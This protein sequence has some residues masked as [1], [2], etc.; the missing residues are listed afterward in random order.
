MRLISLEISNFR[1]IR[2]VSL[3]FPDKVIGIIGP[4]GAGKSSIIEA[5]AWALYGNQAA[6]T[7]R[8]EIKSVFARPTDNCE[9]SLGFSINEEKYRVVRRLVGKSERAEV[10]LYRG[11]SS[12]SVGVNE[13]KAYVGQLLGLDWRGFLSSFLA[14]QQELN[15]LSDLQ[16]SKRRDHLAGMLG[17]ERLDKAI[18]RV[19]EDTKLSQEKARFIENQLV[20]K[21]Q[22]ESRIAQLNGM[23]SG[24]AEPVGKLQAE[25]RAAEAEFKAVEKEFNEAQLKR[26]R[27]TRLKAQIEANEQTLESLN[28]Q[29]DRYRE[30]IQKLAN[31]Q[32]ELQKLNERLVVF[33]EVKK[34]LESLR[35]IKSRLAVRDDLMSR[36]KDMSDELAQLQEDVKKSEE[37]IGGIRTKLGSFPA[38]FEKI[39][40]EKKENLESAREAYSKIKA[41]AT[42]LQKEADKLKSQLLSIEQLGPDSICD[43]CLRPFGEDYDGI[44]GHLGS[45]LEKLQQEMKRLDGELVVRKKSGEEL[46][47]EVTQLERVQRDIYQLNVDLKAVEK[48]R[49]L[50]AAAYEKTQMKLSEISAELK[51]YEGEVFDRSKFEALTVQAEQLE[52]IKQHSDQLKGGLVRLPVAQKGLEE[53]GKRFAD[54]EAT[55][56][57]GRSELDTLGASEQEFMKVSERFNSVRDRLDKVKTDL[58]SKVKEKELHEKELE[59]R[60]DQLKSYQKAAVELEQSRSAHYYGEKLARLF[61]DFRQNLVAGIRPSLSEI[62]SRLFGDMTDGKYT[63]VDLDEK[64]NLR[65]MDSGAYYGVD[66]FSGGEKD[67]ANLCLRLAIS[68]ALTESAGLQRSFVILDEVFG[69]QDAQRKEL[70]LQAMAKLKS[71]FPQILLITHIEDVKDGVEEIIEVLPTGSGW[72]EVRV[73]GASV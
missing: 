62:S 72:S 71:R 56:S 65:I 68:L 26:E 9:V 64:Y 2:N 61:A 70:I 32:G 23:I 38:D 25:L 48:T 42:S 40:A 22:V 69:S 21:V 55:L 50:A 16:P 73:N 8:D 14:R 13:T 3:T 11:D 59:S 35:E 15:A 41:E 57:Q 63:L 12:E 37:R 5:V 10:E 49:Q 1:V 45:E 39:L 36:K 20:D 60:L 43:R 28:E 46:A 51:K 27:W 24:L 58:M 17:I 54:V 30:E 67:L 52:G 31:D 19:K 66:R 53:T 29:A 18:Q 6:R 47:T 34:Q 7:G 33:P 4:N 44:R